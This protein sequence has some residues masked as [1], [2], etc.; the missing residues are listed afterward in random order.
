MKASFLR[1]RYFY[2]GVALIFFLIGFIFYRSLQ[3]NSLTMSLKIEKK[4]FIDTLTRFGTIEP[5]QFYELSAPE[6]PFDRQIMWILPP[7]SFVKKGDLVAQFDPISV[8]D[9]LEIAEEKI[10][11]RELFHQNT[12]INNEIENYENSI[13][14]ESKKSE[15]KIQDGGAENLSILKPLQRDIKATKLKLAD[16]AISQ[17]ETKEKLVSQQNA[18]L[19]RRQEH[20]IKYIKRK[21]NEDLEYLKTYN[22]YAPFDSM[23]LYPLISINGTFKRPEIGDYLSRSQIFA[24][25]PENNVKI[26]RVLLEEHEINQIKLQLPVEITCP[27]L[28][29][30]TFLG[31]ITSIANLALEYP[32]LDTRKYFEVIITFD[33]HPDLSQITFGMSVKAAVILQTYPNTFPIPKIF[34]LPT[35][36]LTIDIQLTSRSTQRTPLNSSEIITTRDFIILKSHPTP[37]AHPSDSFVVAYRNKK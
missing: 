15:K 25:L 30:I 19:L 28:P 5:L 24:R 1:S 17:A 35:D 31:K 22:V 23:V 33:P 12:Q 7:G 18:Y 9:A 10:Q 29:E 34:C 36:P 3:S 27:S 32:G 16:S 20:W 6:A 21:K 14:T 11:D 2:L 37:Q 4:T 26:V 8:E 13:N